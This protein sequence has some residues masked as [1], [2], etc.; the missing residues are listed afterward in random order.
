LRSYD[1]CNRG[2]REDPDDDDERNRS[3]NP[4]LLGSTIFT[5]MKTSTIDSPYFK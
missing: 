2:D 5:P 3:R 1:R 4:M